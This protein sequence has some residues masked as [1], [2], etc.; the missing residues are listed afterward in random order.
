MR[1]ELKATTTQFLMSELLRV[2]EEGGVVALGRVVT[3]IVLAHG[4][5]FVERAIAA[6]NEA[7]REHP[8]R[9]VVIDTA[10]G[11]SPGDGDPDSLDAEIRVGADAGASEVIVLRPH[12]ATARE[13][14]TLVTPLLLPDTP[15]VAMWLGSYPENPSREGIGAMAG[16][17]ITHITNSDDSKSALRAL[18]AN[19]KPGDTDLAWARIT[20][21]RA[22]L[23]SA[24]DGMTDKVRSIAVEGDL[25]RPST[26]LMAGWLRQSL[27]V[28]VTTVHSDS[29]HMEA[30][31]TVLDDGEVVLDRPKGSMVVTISRTGKRDQHSNLPIRTFAD[32]LMEDLRRLDADEVYAKALKA[33]LIDD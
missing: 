7:S 11:D 27:G 2:R 20:L 13:L 15:I 12:G 10:A 31:R 32:C 5:E 25:G 24:L 23:A 9:V 4:P 8:A 14:D 22:L 26:A 30:V 17:R 1:I 6:T 28:P 33:A 16:R 3:L 29:G 19:Y 18:A 21:W